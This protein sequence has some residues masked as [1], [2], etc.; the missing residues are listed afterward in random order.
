MNSLTNISTDSAG[1][2]GEQYLRRCESLVQSMATI[3]Q[4][5]AEHGTKF[6]GNPTTFCAYDGSYGPFQIR[7][8]VYVSI[9]FLVFYQTKKCRIY[10]APLLNELLV[11]GLEVKHRIAII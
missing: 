11:E 5:Q 1:V 8:G 3:N 4:E 7:N 9:K 2:A 6:F 10:W